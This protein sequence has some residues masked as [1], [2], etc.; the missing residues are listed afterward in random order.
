MMAVKELEIDTN[1]KVQLII[2]TQEEVKW[3]D[4]DAY[5]ANCQLPDFS[6]TPDGDFPIGNR[7]KGY[8]DV[9][10]RFNKRIGESGSVEIVELYGGPTINSI[11]S[12]ASGKLRG[13]KVEIEKALSNY[14]KRCPENE[15]SIEEQGDLVI[16]KAK[17]VATHSSFPEK[18][19]N[20]IWI[21]ADFLKELDLIN[22]G[23]YYVVK[24]INE[25]AAGDF[26][27]ASFGLAK[28][29]VYVNGEDMH[30]TMMAI[31]F[32]E[33]YEDGYKLF[34]NIRQTY[35]IYEEDIEEG[36]SK[37]SDSYG[38]TFKIEDYM[39]VLY[40]D[41]NKPF[42]KLM[43]DIYNDNTPWTSCFKLGHGT[44]YAKA[45]PNSVYWGPVFPNEEDLCHEANERTKFDNLILATKLFSYYLAEVVL[46]K[47]SLKG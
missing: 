30:K 4:I 11:P 27:G 2:G 43:E 15:V 36:F 37:Y 10:L 31:T 47:E 39:D 25:V 34:Y 14:L 35:G 19:V 44:S 8:A 16:V 1:K 7:E 46:S 18:G 9:E 24:F 17:G 23:A 13:N 6:F 42:V 40:I 28:G 26:E 38:Y 3:I 45:L 32:M 20:A 29:N 41:S 22:N 12:I 21:L 5:V 33:T